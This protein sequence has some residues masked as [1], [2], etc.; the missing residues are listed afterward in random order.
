MPTS[1]RGPTRD[2]VSAGPAAYFEAVDRKDLEATLAFFTDDATFTVQSAHLTF[3]GVRVSADS[4]AIAE[5]A[6]LIL[7]VHSEL[8]MM[9]ETSKLSSSM[10]EWM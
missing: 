10:C 8:D 4:L 1:Q 7:P 6:T 3:A 5:N 9:R 2:A